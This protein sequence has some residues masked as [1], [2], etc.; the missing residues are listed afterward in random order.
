MPSALNMLSIIV[1]LNMT[2]L[3]DIELQSHDKGHHIR[4]ESVD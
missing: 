3:C 1:Q 4:L 2:E